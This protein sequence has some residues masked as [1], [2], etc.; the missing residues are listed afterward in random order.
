MAEFL[1]SV[2]DS[3]KMSS[4]LSDAKYAKKLSEDMVVAQELGFSGTPMF[5][6]N[7]QKFPGAYSFTDMRA[8]VEGAAK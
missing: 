5:I 7:A 8:A 2:T 6:V 1:A 3:A 4:C